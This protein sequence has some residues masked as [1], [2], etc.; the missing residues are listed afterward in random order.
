ML[1]IFLMNYNNKIFKIKSEKEFEYYAIR[2][3][4]MQYKLNPVYQSYCNLIGTDLN[5][6]KKL[7]QIPFLPIEFFK[8]KKVKSFK[9]S[10][11]K[12]FYS[13]SKTKKNQ[14]K[15]YI[16]NISFYKNSLLNSFSYFY[17]SPTKYNFLAL[18]PLYTENPNSSIIFMV[19][20]LMDVSNN[21]G[22]FFT[23]EY[24][25]IFEK[26]KF[27]EK[28]KKKTMLIGVSFALLDLIQF[29]KINLKNT[30]VIETGGMKGRKKE[31]IREELHNK[32]IDRLGV[33]KIHSEY[34]MTEL[35]SQC[36][37]KGDGVFSSPPWMK[38]KIRDLNDPLKELSVDSTGGIN[39]ID[40]ANQESCSFIATQDQGKIISENKFEVIGRI[41]GSEARGCSLLLS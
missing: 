10:I 35:L 13:S 39:I 27:L 14:S 29:S 11:S 19:K 38:I 8:T 25:L 9:N 12:I 3:F 17:G 23:N 6:V 30:I 18:L 26:L 1:I 28:S 41:D 5:D 32:L 4:R 34:G 36:Y 24:E 16:Q 40:L 7:D 15:H 33:N 20:E 2:I 31:M 37:S 21:K 22:F